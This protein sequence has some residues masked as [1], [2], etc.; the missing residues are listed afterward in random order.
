MI[1]GNV[2]LD[3]TIDRDEGEG[4]LVSSTTGTSAVDQLSSFIVVS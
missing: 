1:Q 3:Y 2:A 4:E